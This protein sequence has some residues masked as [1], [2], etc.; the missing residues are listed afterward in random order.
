MDNHGKSISTN[1]SVPVV[2]LIVTIMLWSLKEDHLGPQSLPLFAHVWDGKEDSF[3][4]CF[5]WLW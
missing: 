5:T 1:P 4:F 3:S 2:A